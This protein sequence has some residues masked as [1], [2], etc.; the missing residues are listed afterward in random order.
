MQLARKLL[1]LKIHMNAVYCLVLVKTN[2]HP[3]PAQVYTAENPEDA[4]RPDAIL[5][6]IKRVGSS[7]TIQH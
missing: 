6:K 3:H 4:K 7:L 1:K 2:K 5:K